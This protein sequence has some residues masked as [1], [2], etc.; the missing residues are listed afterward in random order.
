MQLR[1]AEDEFY[2][3]LSNYCNEKG[4]ELIKRTS[5]TV[6]YKIS[7]VNADVVEEE[8]YNSV[9]YSIRISEIKELHIIY[10]IE[11][12]LVEIKGVGL[13]LS[14]NKG[15]VKD[16]LEMMKIGSG[17]IEKYTTVDGSGNNNFDFYKDDNENAQIVKLKR[18]I[19]LCCN[20]TYVIRL[21]LQL[22]EKDKSKKFHLVNEIEYNTMGINMPEV[23]HCKSPNEYSL[24]NE[25][26]KGISRRLSNIYG[27]NKV[28]SLVSEIEKRTY[29]REEDEVGYT[30]EFIV[31]FYVHNSSMIVPIGTFEYS[32]SVWQGE[33]SNVMP[34][35]IRVS[36]GVVKRL[37][38]VDIGEELLVS[39]CQS[40]FPEIG[41]MNKVE[42][43]SSLLTINGALLNCRVSL[44]D[45][46]L[47][48]ESDYSMED[49]ENDIIDMFN[50]YDKG[51]S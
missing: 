10:T 32:Y 16:V 8:E 27:V 47:T 49:E 39:M 4:I 19:T 3:S 7:E 11:E 21:I 28:E 17:Y 50:E 35:K 45:L 12:G 30:E 18:E 33:E 46:S 2:N 23:L 6:K 20:G 5:K 37:Q 15:I 25:F 42:D 48:V 43:Y 13:Q 24:T 41:I 34:Q 31:D 44:T 26:G 51:D 14:D 29:Y 9:K 1:I 36:F 40:L 38:D 22:K